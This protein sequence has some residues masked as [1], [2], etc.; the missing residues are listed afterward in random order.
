MSAPLSPL[1]ANARKAFG[2]IEAAPVQQIVRALTVGDLTAVRFVGGCVRDGLLDHAPKDIDLATTLTPSQ[3]IEALHAAGLGAAPTGLDHGTVTAIADHFPIE[4]TTLR[5]DVSTDGRRATVAFTTDWETD[6]RRRDFTMN[7]LYLTPDFRLFDPVGGEE[8]LR[9][10]RVRFIGSPENR[11]REDYLRI[12]RFYRFSARFAAGFDQQGLSACA[13]LRG[14]VGALSAE[15]VGDEFSKIL[16][17]PT[18]ARAVAAMMETRVLAEI[19]PAPA[20]LSALERLKRSSPDAPA[21]LGLAALWGEE[22][23]GIDARLRL[24]N[25]DG[26]RR[27]RA[28]DRAPSISARLTEQA[29]RALV[30]RYGAAGFGDAMLLAQAGAGEDLSR[31][32]TIA[33]AFTPPAPPFSGRDALAAGVPEGPKVAAVLAAAEARWIA[34]DFPAPARGKAILAE[35]IARLTA[36]G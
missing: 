2:W 33:A 23:D 10:S 19:W 9:A 25:A 5:A 34:E 18:A 7:A 12:L 11:I 29:I 20:A 21:P 24:S 1:P 8:D 6:A 26:Q 35:E 22:S 4:V 13:A 16:E 17:L 28:I 30:Y 36:T 27:R 31:V 3:V 32:R 14:G 15:R